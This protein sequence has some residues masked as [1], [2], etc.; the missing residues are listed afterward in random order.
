MCVFWF[1]FI[2]Q[3]LVFFPGF[4]ESG[5]LVKD[6]GRLRGV[7]LESWMFKA[8]IISIIP[9]DFF[10]FLIRNSAFRLNRV[11]KIW[12]MLEF[13]RLA[14]TRTHFPNLF[15][16]ARLILYIV[17]IIHWNACFYFAISRHIGFGTDNWTYPDPRQQDFGSFPRQYLTCFYWSCL[18]LTTIGDT[19]QPESVLS[20]CFCIIDSLLGVLIFATIFGN[21]GALINE[22]DAARTEY[23]AKV[24]A[25]KRYMELRGVFGELQVRVIKWFD[26]TWNNK[27]SYNDDK[28]LTYLPEKLRAEI[29][30]H[31]HL[32][33]LRRVDIFKDCE[34]GL[35]VEL[36]LKLH[37]QVFSPGDYICRKG[38][39][40][41]DMYIVKHGRLE[42][43]SEDGK[44]IFVTLSDGS[45][46]GEIS[47]LNIPGSK[48][49]NR[50]TASVRSVG[51]SDLFCLSKKDLWDALKEYPEAKE[52]LMQRGQQLLRKDNLLD[53]GA[54]RRETMR[55]QD[56]DEKFELISDAIHDLKKEVKRLAIKID[57]CNQTSSQTAKVGKAEVSLSPDV[58]TSKESTD[59]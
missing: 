51:Y 33:T 17:I 35:L 45:V 5:L 2:K 12:R 31:V 55:L 52:N 41:K 7:Y 11:V 59:K 24:D 43:V 39:I 26:Y 44:N 14:E 16:V 46:F 42:V 34:P 6:V 40:G 23:Q 22:M 48:S 8:D 47:V 3:Y 1:L 4:L 29:S 38:D 56:V 30:I 15:G 53:E 32:A 25:V 57:N 18:T 37:L 27:Q 50:R 21:V 19:P 28:V 10:Y 49:G 9:L 58:T 20:Y 36:V 13:F 54:A